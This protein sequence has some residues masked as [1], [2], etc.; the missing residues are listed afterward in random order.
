[1]LAVKEQYL[2]KKISKV[3]I[4]KEKGEVPLHM[5]RRS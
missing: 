3:N 4:N 5:P 1:M 2:I